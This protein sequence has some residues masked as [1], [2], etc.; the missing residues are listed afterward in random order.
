MTP[1]QKTTHVPLPP[2]EAFELF[3]AQLDTWWPK[4]RH[5]AGPGSV[6][7]V[8]PHKDGEIVEVRPDGTRKLWGRIIGWDPASFMAFTWCPDGPEEDATVVSVSFT[9]SDGSTRVDLAHGDQTILGDV[10]DAVSTS[11]LLGWDL[12]LGSYCFAA[13]KLRVLA[14]A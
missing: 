3:M 1:L 2:E 8:T 5:A 10:V 9:G 11:Y 14:E 7:E 13:G 4:D 12:V 6:L